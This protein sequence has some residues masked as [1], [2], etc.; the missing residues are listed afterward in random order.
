MMERWAPMPGHALLELSESGRVRR[1]PTVRSRAGVVTPHPRK[2]VLLSIEEI[3]EL[4]LDIA[5]LV[6]ELFGPPK[7]PPRIRGGR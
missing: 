1:I 5:R 3:A 6:A 4:A 2:R 7:A